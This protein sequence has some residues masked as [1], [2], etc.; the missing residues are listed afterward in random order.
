[1]AAFR[2]SRKIV[3]D[4]EILDMK[5]A[6]VAKFIAKTILNPEVILLLMQYTTTVFM[7]SAVTVL[8]V[9]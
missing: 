1:M 2:L 3:T 8:P 5:I 9:S 4:K 7:K 6:A